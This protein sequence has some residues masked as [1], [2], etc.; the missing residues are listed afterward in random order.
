MDHA[1]DLTT[2]LQNYAFSCQ[3]RAETLR[4]E[5]DQLRR[6]NV[7]TGDAAYDSMVDLEINKIRRQ[8][9]AYDAR[10]AEARRGFLLV[11]PDDLAWTFENQDFYSECV[12]ASRVKYVAPMT[13]STPSYAHP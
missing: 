7:K 13:P 5:A 4:W 9:A 10:A 11:D 2:K 12:A 1:I 6:E 8:A 3:G